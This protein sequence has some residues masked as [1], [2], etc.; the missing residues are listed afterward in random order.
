MNRRRGIACCRRGAHG[1]EG[2]AD[3]ADY[4]DKRIVVVTHVA[5]IRMLLLYSEGRDLNE[6]KKVPVPGN[7]EVFVIRRR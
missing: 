1:A 7:R 2:S 5:I 6:Y 3:F 4:A